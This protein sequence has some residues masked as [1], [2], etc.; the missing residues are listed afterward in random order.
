MKMNLTQKIVLLTLLLANFIGAQNIEWSPEYK[1]NRFGSSLF[2]DKG[3]DFYSLTLAGSIFSNNRFLTR[4]EDFLKGEPNKISYKVGNGT[5]SFNEMIVVNGKVVVFLT[6]RENGMYKLYYQVYDK[7]CMPETE[8]KL[9]IEYQSPKG[10]KRGDYFNIIQSKNKKYFVVEYAVPGNKTENDRYGY[11][12]FNDSFEMTG[13]GEYE[14]PYGSK[15]SDVANRYISNTGDLFVG[16]KV[17]NT[18]SKGRVR[19]F[20][21]LKKYIVCFIKGNE[22]EEMDLDFNKKTVTDLSF[23][24]DDKRILT[25]TGLYGEEKVVT[26]GAFY[27][28]MDFKKKTIINEG[29]SEFKKDIIVE[30]WSDREKKRANKREAK[31]KGAPQL[32][33]YDFREVH[34]TKDGGIIVVMEQ[35][36]VV[37]STYTDAKG[38]TYTTRDYYYNDVI[39]YRVQE[40]GTFN[41]I[42]KIQKSQHSINDGGYLSSIGGY[43]TDDTYVCYFND[44]KKNYS[45]GK[46]L[47]NLK[48][49]YGTSYS[50]KSN[51]VARVEL[52]IESGD[53]SRELF[54][55]RSEAKAIAI[56]KRF[57]TDYQ[58]N[59]MFMYFYYGRKEKFGLLKF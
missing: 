46:F 20:S 7:K 19:D 38:H 37:V 26:K 50:K 13:E 34:T 18:N 42:K 57:K 52:A 14:S 55:S 10:F 43:F 32:Y 21:S 49:V 2:L 30:G 16:I 22:L 29:F 51:C 44:N 6:D 36:Y 17:F 1:V 59:E 4:Y 39:V 27:C 25:C 15:E 23:S 35:Y 12:I 53:M 31:G 41:W 33:S 28:Q 48:F 24:S 8:P 11:K 40:N 47:T 5:G 56:P 9:V 3:K 54:V 58:N 45:E